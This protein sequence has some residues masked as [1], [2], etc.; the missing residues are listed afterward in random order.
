MGAVDPCM[1]CQLPD[2]DDR[3]PRCPL[4][5]ALTAEE[6]ATSQSMDAGMRLHGEA[7]A[8]YR[9]D[10][11]RRLNNPEGARG[12]T[13]K[14]RCNHPDRARACQAQWEKDNPHLVSQRKQRWKENN[15][16][17]VRQ[18][19][20]ERYRQY[21]EAVAI[22]AAASLRGGP[23]LDEWERVVEQAQAP[24]PQPLSWPLPPLRQTKPAAPLNPRRWPTPPKPGADHPWRKSFSI[25]G[26]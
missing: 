6:R 19:E 23:G 10:R 11:K 13:R 4:G 20:R 18:R 1:S 5:P 8:A 15:R 24:R 9:R 2:C 14:W 7:L 22:I 3:D 17:L 21:R 12:R 16:E 25:K 26:V